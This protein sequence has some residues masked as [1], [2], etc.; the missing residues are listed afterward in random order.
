V[1]TQ[2]Q[3]PDLANQLSRIKIGLFA[4]DSIG[5]CIFVNSAVVWSAEI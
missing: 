4:S 5:F 1:S 3:K 2:A